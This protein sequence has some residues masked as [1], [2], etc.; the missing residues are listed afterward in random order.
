MPLRPAHLNL[1]TQRFAN[2]RP[3]GTVQTIGMPATATGSRFNLWLGV[4]LLLASLLIESLM[5]LVSRQK[6]LA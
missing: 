5:R 2:L 4:S 3:A 1:R 6:A